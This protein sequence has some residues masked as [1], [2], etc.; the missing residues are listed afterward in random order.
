MHPPSHWLSL[1]I[2]VP[3]VAGLIVLAVG[4]RNP[5]EARGISLLGAIVGFLVTVPLVTGFHTGTSAMQFVELAPWIPRFN[6]NYHLGV[7]GISV[8]FILLNSFITVLV[9]IAG[10]EV[11]RSRVAQY[12]AAFLVMSG[13]L[14]GTFAALDAVLFYAFLMAFAVKVPMWPVHTWLP[15]AH[16]EAPTGG[17]AV[18][19]AI[20]LK[21]GAYGFVRFSLPILPD[22]SHYLAGFMITLSLIAIVYIGLVA[23]VQADMKKL[24]A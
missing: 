10:W 8:L 21:L 9:V 17:S 24:I 4:D 18:L 22:A 12:M 13:L 11:I 1:A 23:L 6:V 7:D 20:L 15:D 5:R 16:V 19:A 3:I 2:W 14:N